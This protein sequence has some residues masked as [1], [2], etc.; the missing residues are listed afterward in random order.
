MLGRLGDERSV[1]SLIQLASRRQEFLSAEVRLACAGSLAQ[2]GRTQ[3][4]FVADMFRASEQP[5]LR[6]Q[7]AYVY[8]Q[9]GSPANLRLLRQMMED[10]SEIVRIYAASAVVRITSR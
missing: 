6:A 4:S 7:S 9:V 8:G 1:D 10:P 3:G 2:L 5:P